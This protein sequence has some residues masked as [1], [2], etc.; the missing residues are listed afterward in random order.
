MKI[1]IWSDVM[2]PFCYI[3]KRRFEEA[4]SA[5]EYKD[6][7]QI[8]WKSF[9]LNPQ[10][11]TDT[12]I[13]INQY[14]ADAKGWTLDYAKQL[15]SQVTDMAAQVGLTYNF[16]DAVVANSFN[17]HRFTHLAKK[18]GKGD[19]AEEQLFQAYFTN[20]QNIDDIDT[21]IALGEATGLDAT[22]TREVLN[23]NTYAEQVHHDIYEAEQLGI[24]GVPFFVMNNHYAVSGAQATEVFLNTLV[25][26]YAEYSQQQSSGLNITEGPS[27]EVDGDC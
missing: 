17:A 1:Q 14:L 23:S 25:S 24:R 12:S 5:F 18:Y 16:D 15:N 22:E 26:A 21:L 19:A 13:S 10:L 7:V 4:L 3:G 11:K 6:K 20:G 8:E 2:C 27:C 9:Q